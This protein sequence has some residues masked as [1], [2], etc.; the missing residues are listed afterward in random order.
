MRFP[1]VISFLTSNADANL[2]QVNVLDN[3]ISN[4]EVILLVSLMASSRRFDV[5]EIYSL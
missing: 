3:R 1:N 4:G 2:A 5:I